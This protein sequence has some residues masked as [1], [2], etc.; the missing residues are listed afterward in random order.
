[1]DFFIFVFPRIIYVDPAKILRLEGRIDNI[2]GMEP[3]TTKKTDTNTTDNKIE[4]SVPVEE[5]YDVTVERLMDRVKDLEKHVEQLGERLENLMKEF[6][7]HKDMH[8]YNYQREIDN[9]RV[10]YGG[11]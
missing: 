5:D 6:D 2:V 10:R 7:K 8:L 4:E 3:N 1:M 11:R 9:Y